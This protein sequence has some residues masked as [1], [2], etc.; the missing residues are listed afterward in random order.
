MSTETNDKSE[1][2][3]EVMGQPC[4]AVCQSQNLTCNKRSCRYWIKGHTEFQNCTL[5]AAE[6]GP[7]TL[8]KVGEFVGLTRMRVCQIEKNALAKI[9]SLLFTK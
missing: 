8:Q 1:R 2:L 7:Y 4:W 5:L 6:K 3:K 9:E